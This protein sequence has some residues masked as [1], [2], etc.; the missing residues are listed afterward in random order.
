MKL[1]PQCHELSGR[2]APGIQVRH[3][4]KELADVRG[5]S[6]KVGARLRAFGV[7]TISLSQNSTHHVI[8][9]VRA[10]RKS[11]EVAVVVV[12]EYSNYGLRPL[13]SRVSSLADRRL[14][15][16]QVISHSL[17]KD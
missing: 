8:V 3:S 6:E 13:C 7:S 12:F 16:L 11:R 14:D 10:V 17:Q 2:Q 4:D 5:P 9:S 15:E 1:G